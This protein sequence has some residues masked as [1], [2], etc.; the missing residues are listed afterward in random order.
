VLQDKELLWISCICSTAA[1]TL[2]AAANNLQLD[3]VECDAVS[4]MYAQQS[5]ELA[6]ENLSA[7]DRQAVARQF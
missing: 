1:A 7:A 3:K 2:S 4:R 6:R 5:V